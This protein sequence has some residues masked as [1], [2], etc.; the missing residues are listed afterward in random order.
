MLFQWQHISWKWCIS[1]TCLFLNENLLTSKEFH[2]Y[3]DVSSNYS[4]NFESSS[5]FGGLCISWRKVAMKN[6]STVHVTR[7]TVQP[8]CILNQLSLSQPACAKCMHARRTNLS[9]ASCTN[10]YTPYSLWAGCGLCGWMHVQNMQVHN[11]VTPFRKK[12]GLEM[13]ALM[14][15]LYALCSGSLTLFLFR[16]M[17]SST[18]TGEEFINRNYCSQTCSLFRGDENISRKARCLASWPWQ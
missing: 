4:F 7:R 10:I 11:I 18:S 9:W 15:F 14:S 3:E 13:T 1:P 16:G 2:E 5:S 12:Q 8:P 17:K 6:W